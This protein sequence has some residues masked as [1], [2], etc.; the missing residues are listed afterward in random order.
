LLEE[1]ARVS[2]WGRDRWRRG[3]GLARDSCWR[4]KRGLT[5]GAGLS[6]A[7]G[8]PLQ[9]IGKLGRGPNLG[10]FG[11]PAAFSSFFYFFFLFL[12]LFSDLIQI[13]CENASNPFKPL[14][15]IF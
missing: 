8:V 5:S 2:S 12:F 9:G 15:E 4:K 11:F 6:V 13:F 7:G 1:G 14:S 3:V 10:R